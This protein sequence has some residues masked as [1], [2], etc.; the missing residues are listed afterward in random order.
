MVLL[1][2]SGLLISLLKVLLLDTSINYS[3][4]RSLA[5]CI[6]LRAMPLILDTELTPE[7]VL[8]PE[9]ESRSLR[10]SVAQRSNALPWLGMSV[11][12]NTG[13]TRHTAGTWDLRGMHGIDTGAAGGRLMPGF[14]AEG[15]AEDCRAE[16][17]QEKAPACVLN[18]KCAEG[19]VS[20]IVIIVFLNFFP[21]SKF[22]WRSHSNSRIRKIFRSAN[23]GNFERHYSLT[24][25]S[26]FQGDS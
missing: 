3:A 4:R 1:L 13:V 23:N 24:P 22:E 20:N 6:R 5:A 26:V 10:R 17:K 12:S 14:T 11:R 16:E 2:S 7:T 15:H 9:S 25:L 19:G 21:A 18:V 8:P